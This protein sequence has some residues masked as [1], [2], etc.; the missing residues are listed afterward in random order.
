MRGQLKTTLQVNALSGII[1]IV[2]LNYPRDHQRDHAGEQDDRPK[3]P[4]H[5][6]GMPSA[7]LLVSPCPM[8][9][10]QPEADQFELLEDHT[11]SMPS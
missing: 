6:L 7:A 1:P 11:L 4:P 8:V 2:L 10:S 3:V 5:F 9:R